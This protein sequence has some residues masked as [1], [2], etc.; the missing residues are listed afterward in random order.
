V[1]GFSE[2][3]VVAYVSEPADPWP[4]ARKRQGEKIDNKKAKK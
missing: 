1:G 3:L 4:K 2:G